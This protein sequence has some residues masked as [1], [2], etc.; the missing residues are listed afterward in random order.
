MSALGQKRTFGSA[1][2]MSAFD[3]K[4][5]S[6]TLTSCELDVETDVAPTI[7][8]DSEAKIKAKQSAI[9][10]RTRPLPPGVPQ[11]FNAAFRLR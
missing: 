2:A 9:G 1:V 6:D 11:S 4:R 5:T 8:P 3:P 10:E 7:A